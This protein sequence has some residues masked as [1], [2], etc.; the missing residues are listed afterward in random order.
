MNGRFV[1]RFRII[2]VLNN[3]TWMQ[4]QIAEREEWKHIHNTQ[5]TSTYEWEI[6]RAIQNYGKD[7]ALRCESWHNLHNV[8]RMSNHMVTK[9]LKIN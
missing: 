3:D 2:Y 7:H 1:G 4:K 5:V 9:R 8:L 6:R